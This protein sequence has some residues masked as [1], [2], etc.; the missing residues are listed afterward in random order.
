MTAK[1]QLYKDRRREGSITLD[2]GQA[3]RCLGKSDQGAADQHGNPTRDPLK[4][5]GDLPTGTYRATRSAPHQPTEAN[6]RSYGPGPYWKLFAISGD[7]LTAAQNGR[8]GIEMH[9]GPTGAPMPAN[10]LRPTHG[11][12]RVDDSTITAIAELPGSDAFD[13]EVVAEAS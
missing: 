8:S 11:C 3:F 9:G 7:A 4:T 1:V 10:A 12:L 5:M 2:T 6:L 13:L